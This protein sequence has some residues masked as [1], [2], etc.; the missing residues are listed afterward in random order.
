MKTTRV[1]QFIW[2]YHYHTQPRIYGGGG[3]ANW[4]ILSTVYNHGLRLSPVQ[5]STTLLNYW[6]Y[7]LI[8]QYDTT[9][10]WWSTTSASVSRT[11]FLCPTTSHSWFMTVVIQSHTIIMSYHFAQFIHDVHNPVEHNYYVLPLCKISL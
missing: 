4:G 9:C 6:I 2:G 7:W 11:Q 1:Q 10:L 5:I 8:L 3:G